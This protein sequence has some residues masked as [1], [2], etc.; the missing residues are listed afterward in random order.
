M[1]PR[2]SSPG[3]SPEVFWRVNK[4]IVNFLF[5]LAGAKTTARTG[6]QRIGIKAP[7]SLADH[8]ALSGQIAYIL[9]LMEGADPERAAALSLF[10]DTA[11]LRV[12]DANWVARTYTGYEAQARK[13]R[14]DQAHDLPF[15]EKIGGLFGELNEGK[16]KEALVALDADSLDMAIQAKYYADN[17]N[18]KAMLW[19]ESIGDAL[20]TKSAK[21]LYAMIGNT[22]I[23]DWWMELE[24]IKKKFES[25]RKNK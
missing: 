4:K 24:S 19:L 11:E 12:G 1:I 22:G 15:A 3:Q 9:A 23:E 2:H 18:K 7:E 25:L 17:G 21:E 16:T 10:H 14:E 13:A 20:A 8:A 5:E 6:W